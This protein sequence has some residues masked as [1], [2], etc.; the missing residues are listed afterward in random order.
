[1][2]EKAALQDVYQ[3]KRGSGRDEGGA[4]QL[5]PPEA[6]SQQPWDASQP[7]QQQPQQQQP[8]AAFYNFQQ[9]GSNYEGQQQQQQYGSNADGQWY[10][11]SGQYQVA[12][13]EVPP[14]GTTGSSD[15]AAPFGG[16]DFGSGGDGQ[17]GSSSSGSSP[18]EFVFPASYTDDAAGAGGR[19]GGSSSGWGSFGSEQ[20][21]EQQGQGQRWGAGPP[22]TGRSS[23]YDMD[24]W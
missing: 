6:G 8:G 5:P 4:F 2:Q 24:D 19:E 14:P 11:G 15:S 18:S 16:G 12:D 17:S 20:Q 23:G 3:R 13:Y 7:W 10:Y 22:Q 1:V 9:P 21:Q